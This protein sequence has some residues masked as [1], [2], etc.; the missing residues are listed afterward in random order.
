MDL[1]YG[2][3]YEEFRREVKAFLAD[4]WPPRGEESELS[5]EEQ[6]DRFRDRAVG[7]GYLARS[8][9]KKYGGSEQEAD[10]V[11]GSVISEEFRRARAPGDP[12]GLGV[13]LLVPT[14]LERGEEWQKEKFIRP[15]IRGHIRWCQGYSEPGSGSDL[16]S[17]QTRG[18]L[19]GDEW[20]INGQKIWTSGAQL[21]DYCFCLVRTEPDQ[22]KH[23][24]IS[25]LLIDMHQPGVEVR[26][27]KQMTG[28]SGFNEV[29]FTDAKTP[30]DWI[31]GERGEGWL[32]SR[33]TL[34]HER[35]GLLNVGQ[36][37]GQLPALVKLARSTKR[38][39]RPAIEDPEIRQKLAEIEGYMKAN[40]HSL[41]YRATRSL[42]G[43]DPGRIQLMAKLIRTE[44]G[45]EVAKLAMELIGDDGLL[46][47]TGGEMFGIEAPNDN[48]GWVTSYMGS[49]GGAIAAG[50]SNIQR[51]I[52]GERGL[53]LPRD[54]AAQRSK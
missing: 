18:E 45:Q 39:G 32:V 33:T 44:I 16:A 52:I 10:A 17:L 23:A 25:Y 8:V 53:G 27:L 41:Y 2:E 50:S 36:A 6:T 48:R 34:K 38:N 5:R 9:P 11:K 47:G 46:A 42:K 1:S 28:N 4:N 7:A 29:F 40:E 22:P 24:G 37:T 12:V 35:S 19:V 51:N 14:L 20:V 30:K 54:R 21:A 15:T 13:G 3:E 43:Q 26:P 31:V 49:L